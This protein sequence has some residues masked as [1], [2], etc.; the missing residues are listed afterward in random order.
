MTISWSHTALTSF[1]TCGRRH[2]LTRV[3]KSVIEPPSEH[4]TWGRQAHE[5]LEKRLAGKAALPPALAYLEPLVVLLTSKHGR[6]LIEEKL[7]VD[8]S[9]R[10]V[11]WRD[12]SA[13][14]RGV[15]DTAIVGVE[16]AVIVDWKTGNRKPDQDQLKLFAA[17]MFAHY[18]FLKSVHTTFVWLKEKKL[19][20]EVF[21]HEQVQS[22]WNEFLPRVQRLELAHKNNTWHP[23]PSGLCQRWCPVTKQHCEFGK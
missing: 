23:K 17:L 4:L 13:W 3:T 15:V 5:A 2:Y 9:F 7:A 14:C 18:P 19:D 8:Q 1:E 12:K 20:K 22:L 11:G 6:R 21:T 16:Q 10:P